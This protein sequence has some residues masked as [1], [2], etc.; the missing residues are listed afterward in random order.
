[1]FSYNSYDLWEKAND[2]TNI[3]SLGTYVISSSKTTITLTPNDGCGV[4]TCT[5]NQLNGKNISMS[6][7]KSVETINISAFKL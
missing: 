1:M 4:E 6:G 7:N 2:G 3:Q 5:I